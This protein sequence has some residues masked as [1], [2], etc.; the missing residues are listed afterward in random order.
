M[1]SVK[2]LENRKGF[3]LIEVLFSLGM[4]VIGIFGVVSLMYGEMEKSM[5]RRNEAIA[6]ALAQEG[7]ELV[8]NIRDNNWQDTG[9]AAFDNIDTKTNGIIDCGS[10][11]DEVKDDTFSASGYG[12]VL[13]GNERYVHG[14]GQE[15]HFK[16]RIIVEDDG[17]DR[18]IITSVTTWGGAGD[19]S[20]DPDE[21][22]CNFYQKCFYIEATLDGKWGEEI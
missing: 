17:A 14:N 12:L 4:F 15:T 3:S 8:R 11:V 16:R 21:S 2:K 6:G 18:K 7:I 1:P 22:N 5:N 19:P 13:D 10:N 9:K 20:G